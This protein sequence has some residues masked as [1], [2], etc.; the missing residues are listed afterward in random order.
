MKAKADVLPRVKCPF[1]FFFFL[2]L[3][4]GLESHKNRT[5]LEGEP[6][7]LPRWKIDSPK[8]KR[9]YRNRM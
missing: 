3:D 6:I 8:N 7:A 5:F 4:V 9:L 2:N 1:S